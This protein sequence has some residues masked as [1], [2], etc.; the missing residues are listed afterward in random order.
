[1]AELNRMYERIHRFP[2]QTIYR[3]LGPHML[4]F[5]LPAAGL[6]LWMIS[7]GWLAI[8]MDTSLLRLFVHC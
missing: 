7:T 1:M 4:G 8:P 6:T 3:I 5:S 2:G